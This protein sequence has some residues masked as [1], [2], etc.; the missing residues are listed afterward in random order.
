MK[1]AAIVLA[2]G[3]SRR[4]QHLNKMLYPP[5]DP[6]LRRVV[7]HLPSDRLE[8]IVVVTGYQATDI[9]NLL[10]DE[11]VRFIHNPKYET[12]MASSLKIGIDRIGK[13]IDGAL[14]CLGDMPDLQRS[15]YEQVINAFTGQPAHVVQPS[16][17]G[18]SGHPVLL[19][20]DLFLKFDALADIDQGGRAIIEKIPT[21][22]KVILAMSSSACLRDYDS[23]DDFEAPSPSLAPT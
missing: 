18:R 10:A 5:A 6:I 16:W 22:N 4:M 13:P 17:Q 8:E 20:A 1:I 14:I 19:S 21:Q 2:A 12:G 7:R 15:D 23:L 9:K 3:M 11:G